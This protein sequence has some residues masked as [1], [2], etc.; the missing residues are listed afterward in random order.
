MNRSLSRLAI[1]RQQADGSSSH[2]SLNIPNVTTNLSSSS[3]QSN[4]G[5]SFRSSFSSINSPI[6][7][8][9][10]MVKTVDPSSGR[11]MINRYLVI[12][13]LGRGVHGKVKLCH[14]TSFTPSSNSDNMNPVS[15]KHYAIK[16]IPKR[17][18]KKFAMGSSFDDPLQKILREIA[19]MKKCLHPCI[20]QLHE[21]IDDPKKDKIY[22]VLEYVEGGE[23]VWKD[24]FDEPLVSLRDAKYIMLDLCVG[25]DYLHYQGIIHR[26]I[27]PQNILLTHHQSSDSSLARAR[28]SAKIADFGVSYFS[29]QLAADNDHIDDAEMTKTAGSPA[30]FAP[31]LCVEDRDSLIRMRRVSIAKQRKLSSVANAVEVESRLRFVPEL[32]GAVAEEGEMIDEKAA[33]ADI[34]KAEVAMEP[35]VKSRPKFITGGVIGIETGMSALTEGTFESGEAT[36]DLDIDD[37]E[38]DDPASPNS[39]NKPIVGKA[40]DVWALG[41]TLFC[42]VYGRLPFIAQS[43]FELFAIIPKTPIQFPVDTPRGDLSVVEPHLIDLLNLMLEKDPFKRIHLRDAKRHPWLRE[44]VPGDTDEEK[45]RWL[46]ESDPQKFIREQM[47]KD[48]A[49][50]LNNYDENGKI[51]VSETDVRHAVS[52]GVV[53]RRFVEAFKRR[54]SRGVIKSPSVVSPSEEKSKFAGW[55]RRSS[56]LFHSASS[57]ALGRVE[58]ADATVTSPPHAIDTNSGAHRRT[59]SFPA[60]HPAAVM[61]FGELRRRS[62]VEESSQSEFSDTTDSG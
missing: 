11:K 37:I 18:K 36:D 47:A 10:V 14:D 30:F 31:E 32:A 28:V 57:H 40:I 24:D 59:S 46:D 26:D 58:S 23:L 52:V 39:A 8:T 6:K 5:T 51:M 33:D 21:V 60:D 29:E 62:R 44:A 17:N 54:F 2:G 56:A 9:S 25:L 20:V 55:R 34:V 27:K 19:I 13:E 7:E 16:I 3:T 35:A 38:I 15:P 53:F 43:E 48:P 49:G 41:V 42:M 4:F 12:R 50:F 45:D 22:L 1:K 61:S